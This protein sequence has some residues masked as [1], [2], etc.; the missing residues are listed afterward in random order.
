MGKRHLPPLALSILCV[1]PVLGL[2]PSD[3]VPD[4]YAVVRYGPAYRY[5][6]AGWL[7]VHVEGRP[8]E[9]GV[10]H[11]RLLAEE[12]AGHVRCY[13]ACQ[14]W[15]APADAWRLTRQ[16]A[17]ALFLRGYD[18]ELLEEMK[19][20]AD[21]ASAAGA[22][23]DGRALD[24]VDIVTLNA[25]AELMCLQSGLRATPTRLEGLVFREAAAQPAPPPQKGHCSAF[26]ATG[27]ATADGQIVFGHI[28]MFDLYP[29]SFYNIWLDIQ[30]DNGHR[31]AM[32]TYPGG[33][34]S[35]MDYYITDAGLLALETTIDQT[36]FHAAGA[37]LAGR[38]RHAL[39]YRDTIDGVVEEL[40][41]NNNGLYTN[42][43][44]LA[45]TRTNE[46]AMFELG[47][48]K[49]RL[50]RSSKGEWFGGT[51]GFYWGCNNAKDLDVRLET[52]AAV[53]DRPANLVWRP[54]DRDMA[55]VK[56]YQQY[57][58]KIDDDFGRIAFSTPP[59]CSAAA[60]DAKYT[61]TRLAKALSTHAIFGPPLGRTWEPTP[62]EV[63]RYPEVRP[64]VSNPWTILHA[65]PP[66][67][68]SRSLQIAQ[69]VSAS[70]PA[71]PTPPP[72]HAVDLAYAEYRSE[73]QEDDDG[74]SDS[75]AS[76]A[77]MAQP[78]WHGTLLPKTDA[79]VWLAAAFA[80][81]H[82]IVAKQRGRS[83]ASLRPCRCADDADAAAVS[84]FAA[85]ARYLRAAAA[86]DV[87][88]GH[89]R[90]ETASDRWYQIASGKGV[91]LLA[92][93]RNAVGDPAFFDLMDSFGRAHAGKEVTTAEFRAHVE[94]CEHQLP[95]G[96]FDFWLNETGLPRLRLTGAALRDGPTAA[97]AHRPYR[98]EARLVA[99]RGPLPP[100]MDITAE[101]GGD[102]E[103]TQHVAI[104]ADSGA[105]H[106]EFAQHPARVVVDKYGRTARADAGTADVRAFARELDR[107]LIVAGTQD[108]AA[109]N[110]AAAERLQR[111]LRIEWHNVDVPIKLDRDVTQAD[112]H[113]H[114][115]LLV[116][117]ARTNQVTSRFA[118][119][120]PVSFGLQS[121]TV[122][123]R[124]CAHPQSAVLAAAENPLN[125]R[126]TCVVLAGLSAS[127]TYQC[128]DALRPQDEGAQVIVL[129]HAGKRRR[130]VVAPADWTMECSAERSA[131]AAP[132]A[133]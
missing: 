131:S 33:V 47:T 64:V 37:P 97:D 48:Y 114:H 58:G 107:T 51:E 53:N 10:Q 113:A 118:A 43:W 73:A 40:R 63:R 71:D 12:I 76:P 117:S 129:P 57:K 35:A 41:K 133:R 11:G 84:V 67:D 128:A 21:G 122:R 9:R 54:A 38:M 79:D 88:L 90:S 6:Q 100:F 66:P 75:D 17:E 30:P 89:T 19:G 14:G 101:F 16:L 99:D 25:W 70:A 115:L 26:A 120:L 94:A 34:Y 56:L 110:A 127:A 108:D 123:G 93:M 87:P 49:D 104:D 85:R 68:D 96:F 132:R 22:T 81:Y 78:F 74:K 50:Y 106:A 36:R 77:P 23:F 15:K 95:R 102:D 91:L 98:F 3:F 5:P 39:Q 130:C 116:G 83:D 119:A 46:I 72:T 125:P 32:Q 18:R 44:M 1:A 45:D 121:F 31:I 29:S 24:L 20:I 4:P 8:Y 13:A 124:T 42:E 2:P 59:I 92:E 109:G 111:A 126:Y 112:L 69:G 86:G 82:D 60:V 7:V 28:T 52:I 61:T 55:W 103:E 105:L 62:Q 80:E 65:V 27:P